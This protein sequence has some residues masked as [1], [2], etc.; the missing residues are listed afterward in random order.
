MSVGTGASY[1]VIKLP[2]SNPSK[3]ITRMY[4]YSKYLEAKDQEI[5][6]EEYLLPPPNLPGDFEI[7]CVPLRYQDSKFTFQVR[8]EDAQT[9]Q[10]LYLKSNQDASSQELTFTHWNLANK[11]LQ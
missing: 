1:Q 9:F 5:I 2:S 11:T 7:L 6:D 3:D 4:L 8:K 10:N